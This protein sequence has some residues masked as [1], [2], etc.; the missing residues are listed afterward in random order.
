MNLEDTLK[1]E[2]SDA[3]VARLSYVAEIPGGEVA[4]WIEELGMI[5][6]IK[7]LKSELGSE[8]F[9]NGCVLVNGEVPVV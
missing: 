7:E 8:P 3:R 2:L 4:S 1:S 5:E 9:G 6:S